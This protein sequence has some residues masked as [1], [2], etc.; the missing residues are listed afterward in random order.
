MNKIGKR[1]IT[2]TGRESWMEICTV[3]GCKTPTLHISTEPCGQSP[4]ILQPFTKET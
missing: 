3:Y 2:S 4:L 1:L